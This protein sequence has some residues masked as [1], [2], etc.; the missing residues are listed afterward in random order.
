MRRGGVKSVYSGEL[1]R[2]ASRKQGTSAQ[3]ACVSRCQ[4]EAKVQTRRTEGQ[5]VKS[6][7]LRMEVGW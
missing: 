2:G 1:R 4:P 7:R 6:V 5:S 3:D